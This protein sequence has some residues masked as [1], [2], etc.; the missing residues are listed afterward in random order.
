MK[1]NAAKPTTTTNMRGV[2]TTSG[3]VEKELLATLV[4]F[5]NAV[6]FTRIP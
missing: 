4:V 5:K 3:V 1:L 6:K 2:F